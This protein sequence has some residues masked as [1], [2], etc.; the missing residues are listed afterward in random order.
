MVLGPLA[1]C[2]TLLCAVALSGDS[3][4]VVFVLCPLVRA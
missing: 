1:A 4:G 2:L 3:M